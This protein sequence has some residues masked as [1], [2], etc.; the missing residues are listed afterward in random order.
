[1]IAAAF[2]Y[3]HAAGLMSMWLMVFGP[4]HALRPA[5]TR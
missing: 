2:Y 1:M 3:G 4:T 5:A